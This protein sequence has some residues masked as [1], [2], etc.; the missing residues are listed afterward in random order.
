MGL[1]PPRNSVSHVHQGVPHHANL[2]AATDIL[3]CHP[4]NAVAVSGDVGRVGCMQARRALCELATISIGGKNRQ[5]GSP[6]TKQPYG[7]DLQSGSSFARSRIVSRTFNAIST[8]GSL[9][10]L[11]LYIR[12]TTSSKISWSISSHEL[13]GKD[14]AHARIGLAPKVRSSRLLSSFLAFLALTDGESTAEGEWPWKMATRFLFRIEP[15]NSPCAAAWM[16]VWARDTRS[17]DF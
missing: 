11:A 1:R 12:L 3:C 13:G 10:V 7:E 17:S 15:L 14:K 5:A 2:G 8:T 9:P 4:G 6:W 16:A